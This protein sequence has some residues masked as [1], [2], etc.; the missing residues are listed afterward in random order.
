MRTTRRKAALEANRLIPWV[1]D[2]KKQRPMGPFEGFHI[3]GI[4][5]GFSISSFGPQGLV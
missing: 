4:I 3:V 5:T 1:S 2:F